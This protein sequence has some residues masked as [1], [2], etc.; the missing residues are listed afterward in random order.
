MEVGKS[1]SFCLYNETYNEKTTGSRFQL[2]FSITKAWNR[3]KI[4]KIII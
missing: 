3:K 4:D 1:L 2:I